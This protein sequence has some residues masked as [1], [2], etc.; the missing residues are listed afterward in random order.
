MESDSPAQHKYLT[1]SK[2]NKSKRKTYQNESSDDDDDNE[3]I[4]DSNQ[5]NDNKL[6]SNDLGKNNEPKD[7]QDLLFQLFPSQ[8]LAQKIKNNKKYRKSNIPPEENIIH[9]N[10]NNKNQDS[11]EEDSDLW[12]LVQFGQDQN[13]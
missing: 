1:R 12:D 4:Y 10:I 9:F 7:F 8:H 13:G 6:D 11:S 5:Y 3:S 2:T